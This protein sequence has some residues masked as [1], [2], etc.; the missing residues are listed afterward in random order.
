MSASG[1]WGRASPTAPTQVPAAQMGTHTKVVSSAA[2]PLWTP[3]RFRKSGSWL[4]RGTTTGRPVSTTR[5][6][7]P[8]PTR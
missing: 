4:A 5:P 3:V 2:E 8:S 7:M 1:R 6:M